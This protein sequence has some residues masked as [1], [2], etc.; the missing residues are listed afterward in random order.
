MDEEAGAAAE[1]GQVAGADPPAGSGEQ[2]DQGGVRAGV[3]EDFTDRDEVGDLG[4]VQQPGEADDLDRDVAG[5]E[6]GLDLREVAGGAAQYG[7]LAGCLP[8]PYEMRDRVGEPVDLFGVGTQEGA[9]DDAVALGARGGAQCLDTLVHGA[10]RLGEPV[11]QV[12]Q[13]AAAAA[14][15]AEGVPGG[16]GAVGVREVAR[17]VVEIG[18][19]G[20]APAVDRLAGV[21]DGGDCVPGGGAVGAAAE[22]GGE[23]QPLGDGGVLVLVE[24]DHPIFVAQ[25]RADLGA[26]EG[27][28]GGERD[29]VAEV[30][31][32]AAALGVP[33]AP[34]QREELAP[35]LGGLGDLAQLG[36]GEP[37]RCER[38][39]ELG[40]V[41][42]ELF[43]ADEVLGELG[44]ECQQIADQG[45]ERPG[46][47]RVRAGGLA[48]HAGGQLVAGGVGEEAGGGF[49]SYPQSVLG[50]EPSGEGVVRGDAG[51]TRGVVRVDDVRIGDPGGDQGLA[52]ALGE[53]ARRLVR[54]REPEDLLG[55]DLSGPDQ[56]HHARRHHRG[57]PGP[58][59]GHD[60]LRRGRRGD[61]GRL[62]RGEGDPEELLELLGIGDR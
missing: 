49:E 26:G 1:Q 41:L 60:H 4:Q 37:G 25:D 3:L 56:P 28:L 21:T 38:T 43:R 44:V 13:A 34:G 54:E 61:A 32:V 42:R 7:D 45:G 12:Q 15:L 57:L 55:G 2:P 16:G 18:D 10:Q 39:E 50:E 48:Q 35:G 30:E 59:S 47:R 27:E 23:Q 40:V 46:Q 6:G 11:G 51:L 9:A 33:V 22:E 36:V 52:D 5:D 17:E 20:A 19:G 8:G 53:L 24:Q 14:V 62:L 29:L 58:G 31:E